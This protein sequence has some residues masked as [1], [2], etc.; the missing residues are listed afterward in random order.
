MGVKF[1]VLKYLNL[2]PSNW[3]ILAGIS[4][5][6]YITSS[7]PR[8]SK[9]I[10]AVLAGSPSPR[11][12][13]SRPSSACR[14][15]APNGRSTRAAL[16]DHVYLRR[17]QA[18]AVFSTACI[19]DD[20]PCLRGVVR[21]DASGATI[22]EGRW[23]LIA[24][25]FDD[26]TKKKSDFRFQSNSAA[27][28]P[29]Q[30]EY[31]GRFKLG[32]STIKED[33]LH[34]TFASRGD[35]TWGVDG[36]GANQFGSFTISG[37]LS[38]EFE[39]EL[40]KTVT[41]EP[42]APPRAQSRPAAAAARVGQESGGG[43]AVPTAIPVDFIR[44][45]GQILRH[46]MGKKEA[47][48]F[49]EPVDPIAQG[50]PTYSEIIQHPMDFGT[51][52]EKIDT[53]EY[54]SPAEFVA[55]VRLVFRNARTF[56]PGETL[57]HKAAVFLSDTFEDKARELLQSAATCSAS[58]PSRGAAEPTSGASAKPKDAAVARPRKRKVVEQAHEPDDSDRS[59]AVEVM[60]D[61]MRLMEAQIAQLQATGSLDSQAGSVV[62]PAIPRFVAL[63][64]SQR[65]PTRS[66]SQI[67]PRCSR[68]LLRSPLLR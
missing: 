2:S 23:A 66:R 61:K 62:A 45:C 4:I 63:C 28:F 64:S 67:T 13:T 20:A 43:G 34:L 46:L 36:H 17:G 60:R 22:C 35:G 11:C 48:W 26:K 1:T 6:R 44:K 47:F 42:P 29:A 30:G 37:S 31:S 59:S 16:K 40:I 41:S 58:A 55:D 24:A 9:V 14:G 7:P 8:G 27:H 68:A 18:F 3:I 53:K 51:I 15:A 57:P 33:A 52:K 32:A 19:M 65:R 10:L 21:R 49:L 50:V 38:A 54:P 25:D 5:P 12:G 56:N 39:L